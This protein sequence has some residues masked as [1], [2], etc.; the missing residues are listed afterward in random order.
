MNKVIVS[1]E[2]RDDLIRTYFITA[3]TATAVITIEMAAVMPTHSPVSS[4]AG[5]GD[6]VV[7][8]YRH[9]SF[10]QTHP[11]SLQPSLRQ[12]ARNANPTSQ[13]VVVGFPIVCE[14]SHHSVEVDHTIKHHPPMQYGE[15]WHDVSPLPLSPRQ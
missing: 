5:G 2:T 3:H 4:F 11:I 8:R 15:V 13:R 12:I 6:G 1:P 14:E 10:V 9:S 7:A